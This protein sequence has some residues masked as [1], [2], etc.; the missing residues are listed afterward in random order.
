MPLITWQSKK[1]WSYFYI[2]HFLVD[3]KHQYQVKVKVLKERKHHQSER[4][5][6]E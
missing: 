3:F 6:N 4:V 1:K 5:L 2:V